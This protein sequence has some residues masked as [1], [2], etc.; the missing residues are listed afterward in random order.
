MDESGAHYANRNKLDTERQMLHI[1]YMW[2]LGQ[3]NRRSEEQNGGCHGWR[4]G[5]GKGEDSGQELQSFSP[6]R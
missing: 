3:S 5:E 2:N 4:V 1:I 6:T